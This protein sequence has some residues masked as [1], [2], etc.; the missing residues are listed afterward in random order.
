MAAQTAFSTVVPLPVKPYREANR[1]PFYSVVPISSYKAADW[2]AASRALES[3]TTL[4]GANLNS[5]ALSKGLYSFGAISDPQF[6][7][8]L[9]G[10]ELNGGAVYVNGRYYALVYDYDSQYNLT[11]CRWLCYDAET[12]QQVSA[13]DCPLD[14]SYI[15]ADRTYD[16]TT[17]KVYS[18]GY[19]RTG[20]N[21]QLV[22]TSLTD[23][24]PSLVGEF[25]SDISMLCIAA[26]ASGQLYTL[27][28]F[29]NLYSVNPADASVSLIGNTDIFDQYETGYTQS[30]TFDSSTGL[31]Y[32]AEFHTEGFGTAAGA[33]YAIDPATA[34]TTKVFDMPSKAEFTGLFS[35]D[36][37]APDVP[38]MITGASATPRTEGSE[39]ICFMFTAPSRTNAG[40]QMNGNLT[41]EVIVDNETIDL[42]DDVAPG[43]SVTTDYYQFGHGTHIAKLRAEN[44]EGPGLNTVLPFFAGYDVPAAPV[45]VRLTANE[46]QAHLVW[47]APLSG[48]EG[49]A[50]RKPV[51]YDVV[52]M[53]GNVSVASGLSETSFTE[54]LPEAALYSYTVTAVSPDGRGPSAVSNS[55]VVSSFTVPYLETFDTEDSGNLFSV[56]DANGDGRTWAWFKDNRCMRYSYSVLNAADDWLVSPPVSLD[57]AHSYRLSFDAFKYL[58]GYNEVVEVWYGTSS[59]P[60]SMSRI[61]V[62]T[63]P[64]VDPSTLSF[65]VPALN[66]GSH[67]FALHAVSPANQMFIYIDNFSVVEEGQADVPASVSDLTATPE[68]DSYTDIRL[69]FTAPAKALNGTPVKGITR[70][71]VYRGS[72]RDA[73]VSFENPVP[74]SSITWTDR[75]LRQGT[76]TYRVVAVNDAG[77]SEAATVTAY[78]GIDVPSPATDVRMTIE[79]GNPV[80]EWNA[81]SAGE[82][83]GNMDGLLTY[84]VIRVY[85]ATEQTIAEGIADVR[86]TDT[87][88]DADTQA[89][90]YY[91]V[92]ARTTA[93]AA[94]AAYSPG[95]VVGN[96]YPAPWSESFANM[97]MQSNPWFVTLLNGSSGGWGITSQEYY[98]SAKA[99]DGDGGFAAFDGYHTWSANARLTSPRIAISHLANPVL[100]FY[101]YHYHGDNWSGETGPEYV[102]AQL[103][104]EISMDGGDIVEIPGGLFELYAPSDGWV[105]HEISLKDYKDCGYVNISFKGLNGYTYNIYVDNINIGADYTNNVEVSG[106]EGP[107][108]VT[109]GMK[110]RFTGRILNSGKVASG[111]VT[112]SLYLDGGKVTGKSIRSIAAGEVYEV[113]LEA[114]VPALA[115]VA[116]KC[117][118][119]L[120][121][122]MAG[123]ENS[124]DNLSDV[125]V[126][127]VVANAL[128]VV[129]DLS[130]S[131]I[132]RSVSLSWSEPAD[133]DEFTLEG[134]HVYCNGVR[135]TS[136]PQTSTEY[137]HT[138]LDKGVYAYAVSAVYEEG[139]SSLSDIAE[140]VLEPDGIDAPE[141][142]SLSVAGVRGAIEFSGNSG[143]MSVYGL[144]GSALYR[145]DESAGKVYLIPGVYIVASSTGYSA[146]IR[147]D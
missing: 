82:N 121:L 30:M 132:D 145:T 98:P 142:A 107:E 111:M 50:V 104:V 131:I 88:V 4:T 116:G 76:Y 60:S 105:K 18:L 75:S 80:V 94:P 141:L 115:S 118:W 85:N 46:S 73:V 27:D 120:R 58:A 14:F 123:D 138:D 10:V 12:W 95:V 69:D 70:I 140:A 56:V 72:A 147:V 89:Y 65:V 99:Q 135:L 31:I 8:L 108:S 32:W 101:M 57:G 125:I 13:V 136:S 127:P 9:E 49:G 81:P 22:T 42:L 113:E 45:G 130:A 28:T 53:P 19:D 2:K 20:T 92:V 17:G 1:K 15:A 97:T 96:P 129:T 47:E 5:G 3:V 62:A 143:I 52:R 67:Y 23:G 117:E 90:L 26:S 54:N 109:A 133:A 25:P 128:P 44:S 59:D 144:D 74:G 16:P 77:S 139:E 93:G 83:G 87:E 134:Y 61:G 64:S 40:A 126:T 71:D 114:D 21:I 36:G 124:L 38:A 106:F 102:R 103:Q 11:E 51:T 55:L 146:K 66:T 43:S 41:I 63:V 68:G 6:T 24:A 86:L 110:A 7:P 37:G 122:S 39:E 29:A 84:D 112:A 79:N 33:L 35:M 119:Q 34:S 48:A 91:A 100:S 78:A 137:M